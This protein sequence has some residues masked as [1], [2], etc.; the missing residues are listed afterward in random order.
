MSGSGR[1]VL[2]DVYEWSGIPPGCLGVV[3]R[4]FRMSGS[5]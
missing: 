1:D 2:P 3:E 5:G 4:P